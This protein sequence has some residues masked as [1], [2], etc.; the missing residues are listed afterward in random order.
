[1]QVDDKTPM[2]EQLPTSDYVLAVAEIG[3]KLRELDKRFGRENVTVLLAYR[4]KFQ[5]RIRGMEQKKELVQEVL[6]NFEKAAEQCK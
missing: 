4:C 1:M 3:E 2:S 5:G 6:D